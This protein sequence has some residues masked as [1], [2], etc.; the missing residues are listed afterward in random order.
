M[1]EL[2]E[3]ETTRAGI[4]QH[5]LGKKVADL[6]VRNGKL[7]WPIPQF[8]DRSVRGTHLRNLRRRGKYLL[9]DF[10][11]I[12]LL[13]HLGMSGSLRLCAESDKPRKHDHWDLCFSD[14][15]I[16]RY[17][18]PRRF[19]ALL[20]LDA[21]SS[22]HKLLSH[23]GPEPLSDAFDGDHLFRH[24]RK[25][26]QAVKPFIMD[27]KT[28][29]GVGNIY[30]SEALFLA[31]IH[32]N[33]AAG[34]ISRKRYQDLAKAIKLILTEAIERGGTTLRDFVGGDGN[35]GYFQQE[36]RVY[37]RAGTPCQVCGNKLKN[38]RLGQRATV[39]CATCQT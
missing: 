5:I 28:V 14:G 18:D 6:L 9:F 39:Y 30:A 29:V 3:V 10:E 34:R 12:T 36:L 33:R 31:G 4:E 23:L 32:P 37:G 35:P 17:H 8:L 19:G 24:S 1:P 27:S 13:I 15:T 20:G 25:R 21:G 2:P 16:L 26:S 22:D 38:L 7:R 11:Q